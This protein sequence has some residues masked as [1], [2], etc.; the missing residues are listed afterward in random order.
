MAYQPR[1]RA[2]A[3]RI[4]DLLDTYRWDGT[5]LSVNRI[6]YHLDTAQH[7]T[8]RLTIQRSL[9]RMADKGWGDYQ[10]RLSTG[11]NPIATWSITD[12]GWAALNLACGVTELEGAYA[13]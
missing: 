1:P 11:R 12:T 4:L 9:W 2:T 5:A 7:P 3:L 8:R 10:L 13:T 6:V